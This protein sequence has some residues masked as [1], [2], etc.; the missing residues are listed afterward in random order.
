[1]LHA[2]CYNDIFACYLAGGRHKTSDFAVKHF[3]VA[4]LR[5][6][7][8]L[9]C[10]SCGHPSLSH[11]GS[12]LIS[13]CVSKSFSRSNAIWGITLSTFS[14][15]FHSMAPSQIPYYYYYCVWLVV[16][17]RI[18][19]IAWCVVWFSTIASRNQFEHAEGIPSCHVR[20]SVSSVWFWIQSLSSFSPTIS[21]PSVRP[22]PPRLPHC[23]Y[24]I[25]PP[26]T[27]NRLVAYK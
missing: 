15:S 1:M 19:M 12:I 2:K 17:S 7:H 5:S 6:I 14:A 27:N 24:A 23:I 3:A 20:G 4:P 25:S 10:L 16:L 22:L 8:L 18:S 11:F 21:T 13:N 9:L 26:K